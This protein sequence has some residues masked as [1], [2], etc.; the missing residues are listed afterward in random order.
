MARMIFHRIAPRIELCQ[1]EDQFGFREFRSW[2]H[3][4]FVAEV[5]ISRCIEFPVPL[6]IAGVDLKKAF[7]RIQHIVLFDVLRQQGIDEGS[8][9][10]LKL[11]YKHQYGVISDHS[12]FIFRGLRQGGVLSPILFNAT[13]KL[14][15]CK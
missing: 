12:F 9:S 2:I 6:W 7:D 5:M 11:L 13:L 14:A 3:A 1:S 10:L 4:L 15:M 8:L